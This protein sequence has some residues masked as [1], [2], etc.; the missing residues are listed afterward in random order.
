MIKNKELEE[1]LNVLEDKVKDKEHLEQQN[2][3]LHAKCA[4]LEVELVMLKDKEKERQNNAD[5]TPQPLKNSPRSTS[6]EVPPL[7][8]MPIYKSR[9]RFLSLS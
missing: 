3:E 2:K 8:M 1:K 9:V 4:Q 5:L 7:P 6:G